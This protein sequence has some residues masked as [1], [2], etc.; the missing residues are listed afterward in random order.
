MSSRSPLSTAGTLAGDD[1]AVDCIDDA[2]A[3][4]IAVTAAIDDRGCA[5]SSWLQCNGRSSEEG[6]DIAGW[7]SC[8]G[9]RWSLVV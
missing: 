2:E 6:D 1:I 7:G 3:T 4:V 8:S 9:G 5:C